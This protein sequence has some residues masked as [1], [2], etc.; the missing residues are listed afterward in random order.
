MKQLLFILFLFTSVISFSQNKSNEEKVDYAI[1]KIN[2]FYYEKNFDS[3]YYYFE[4]AKILFNE[5]KNDEKFVD[6]HFAFEPHY[7][8]IGLY[9]KA[10]KLCMIHR[11]LIIKHC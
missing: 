5:F 6:L 8:T 2:E 9:D 1:E 11:L 3:G 7:N 10:L 4:K